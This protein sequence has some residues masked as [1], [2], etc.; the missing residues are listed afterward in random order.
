M[1][2]HELLEAI[3]QAQFQLEYA[4]PGE[5]TVCLARLNAL[6][7][8]AIAGTHLTRRELLCQPSATATKHTSEH[9]S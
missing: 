4:E 9:N 7:D 3:L 6:V 1:S 8:Q 2:R 5:L